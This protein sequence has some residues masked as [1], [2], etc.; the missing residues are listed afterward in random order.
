MF[1]Q[2]LELLLTW[3]HL[4][5]CC[6]GG[7]TRKE[8][9]GRLRESGKSRSA[10]SQNPD[11]QGTP[12]VDYPVY[13]V[14]PET[15]FICDGRTEGGYYGD[16][17]ARCQVFHVCTNNGNN[18]LTKNSFLCPNS[19]QFHQKILACDWWYNV[20]CSTTKDFYGKLSRRPRKIEGMVARVSLKRQNIF[21]RPGHL[22]PTVSMYEMTKKPISNI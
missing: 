19:T 13:N 5:Q 20:D 16:P 2:I 10:R 14:V 17:E 15:S 4:S 3:L 11:N 6:K 7:Y 18:S 12:G 1:H 21:L 22:T 8:L 9:E